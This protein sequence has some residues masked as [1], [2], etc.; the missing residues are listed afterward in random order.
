MRFRVLVLS[1]LFMLAACSGY[2]P[3]ADLVGVDRAAIVA[4]MGPPE[5]ERPVDGGG[6]R[7]EFPHGPHGHH[8]WF[9]YLDSAGKAMRAEQVLTEQ[10]F[11]RILPGMDS[12]AVRERLGRPSEESVLGRSRGVV[13]NYRYEGPF[14]L[15]FQVE[16]AADGKVRSAG[17]GTPPE[18]ERD[19]GI[20][21]P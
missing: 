19:V 17:Y 7:L 6:T 10:N 8:T 15:W 11:L 14:C 4:R 20:I 9:V 3:P 5:R 18:C 2:A 16:I 1:I 13:W 21:F 12:G